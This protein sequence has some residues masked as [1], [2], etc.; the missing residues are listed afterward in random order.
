MTRISG[1][2]PEWIH[3]MSHSIHL[4]LNTLCWRYCWI[5][6]HTGHKYLPIFSHSWRSIH[7]LL[8]Y[9]SWPPIFQ[10]CNLQAPWPFSHGPQPYNWY[11]TACLTSK[12]SEQ[13]D[14][15]G[16]PTIRWFSFVTVL[17]C[18]PDRCQFCS[19]PSWVVPT[20]C[21]VDPSINNTCMF[22]PLPADLRKL[23]MRPLV[24]AGREKVNVAEVKTMT[25]EPLHHV[26]YLYLLS[27]SGWAGL[28]MYPFIW[29]QSANMDTQCYSLVDHTSSPW[30][31]NQVGNLVDH[32]HLV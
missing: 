23:P 5:S 3:R 7:T 10:S 28:H 27:G 25:F 13:P 19:C 17:L 2:K 20:Y 30:Q 1:G 22:S 31:A 21:Y 4:I 9:I 14:A 12:M 18:V 8:T 24:Q 16:A 32:C 26:T 11:I 29:W 15:S 6:T